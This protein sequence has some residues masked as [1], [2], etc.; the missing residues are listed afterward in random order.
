MFTEERIIAA[1]STVDGPNKGA[2]FHL[3]HLPSDAVV[4]KNMV[5]QLRQWNTGAGAATWKLVRLITLL[6]AVTRY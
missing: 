3:A 4:V 2:K 1:T 5:R 6:Q